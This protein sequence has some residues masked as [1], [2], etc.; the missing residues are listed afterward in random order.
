[1]AAEYPTRGAAPHAP[2]VRRATCAS[3][4]ALA[5]GLAASAHAQTTAT[6]NGPTS[7]NWTDPANWSTPA[8]P[9]N[10]AIKYEAVLNATGMAHTVTLNS[11]ITLD[12]YT[13]SS[14][15]VTLMGDSVNAHSIT[16]ESLATISGGAI[17]G[18]GLFDVKGALVIDNS[19]DD[20]DICDTCI[21]HGGTATWQGT[22]NDVCV[23]EGGEFINKQGA[24]FN[25]N[26]DQTWKYNGA[27]AVPKF[28]IQGTLRKV[29][30]SGTTKF[31]GVDFCNDGTI[32]VQSG[33]LEIDGFSLPTGTLV[34]GTWKVSNGATLRL[35][36]VNVTANEATIEV[37]DSGSSFIGIENLAEN[38]VSGMLTFADGA[39]FATVGDFENL[40]MLD[41]GAASEFEV[42]AGS[43]LLNYRPATKRLT[44]G[45]FNVEGT[46]R[47]ANTGISTI[48]NVLT[49]VGP[50]AAIVDTSGNN[51][52]ANTS[53]LSGAGHLTIAGGLDFNTGGDFE[54]KGGAILTV[55]STSEFEVTGNLANLSGATFTAGNFDI[56]GTLR[57]DHPGITTINNPL[58][59][60]GLTSQFVNTAGGDLLAPLN[61]ID[62]KGVLTLGLGRDL[63][64]TGPLTVLGRVVLEE[65]PVD[66]DPSEL[67]VTGPLFHNSGIISLSGGQVHAL[68]GYQQQPGARL[69]GN[70][71]IDTG[72][73]TVFISL[74][75]RF[76]AGDNPGESRFGNLSLDAFTNIF[77]TSNMLVD[78]GNDLP[79]MPAIN[80]TIGVNG[81]V[82]FLGP[83][84]F[85]GTLVVK[86]LNYTPL[87]GE[88]FDV[89]FY[90]NRIGEFQTYKG[91]KVGGGLMLFPMY[92]Q[93]R[94]RLT[95]GLVPAPG[96]AALLLA[97]SLLGARRRRQTRG[98]C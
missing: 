30:G 13:Q 77:P 65:S 59:L 21:E 96:T 62:T 73:P 66:A 58:A 88:F 28:D 75:G 3:V 41:V 86:K 32:D 81:L 15:D 40:G 25:I 43:R 82:Q 18:V 57:V 89:L 24:T 48:S 76:G 64:T 78:I 45:E 37:M 90:E 33:T 6:W 44:N 29:G 68:N 16:V 17:F 72:T 34:T 91:L 95:V 67:T 39:D 97:G 46:L 10:G 8:F 14:A 63:T 87:L 53:L 94:L 22:G 2:R 5:A 26:N 35:S 42:A 1:M 93:D 92:L 7:G 20:I 54:V 69:Q 83:G 9:N 71:S 31:E 70:G 4:V 80:D 38:G 52:L 36:T 98:A 27:G 55:D 79:A 56:S 85:A 47:F 74:Q 19:M 60:R 51:A 49:L 50:G 61:L 23:G 12:G 84:N 11:H